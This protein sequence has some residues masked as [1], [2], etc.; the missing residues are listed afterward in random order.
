MKKWIQ[1]TAR[2]AGA[3]KHP[4]R[5]KE[6]A[7]RAGMPLKEYERKEAHSSDKSLA[8]AARLGLRFGKGGDLHRKGR[9]HEGRSSGRR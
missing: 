3:I 9:H 4:G 5:M 8:S 2:H 6:G 7:A 1:G